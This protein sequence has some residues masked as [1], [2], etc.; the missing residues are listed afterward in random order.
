MNSHNHPLGLN[1]EN[2]TKTK[3]GYIIECS[4]LVKSGWTVFNH[5]FGRPDH[6]VVNE[7]FYTTKKDGDICKFVMSKLKS[8]H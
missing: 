1:I 4:Y 8:N 2:V 7:V 6:T 5:L 3:F